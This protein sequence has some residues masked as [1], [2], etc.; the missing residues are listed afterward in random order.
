MIAVALLNRHIVYVV[1]DTFQ[2][3]LQKV[4]SLVIKKLLIRKINSCGILLR[5]RCMHGCGPPSLWEIPSS[6]N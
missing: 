6:K 3:N 2:N 1:K 4:L 5:I